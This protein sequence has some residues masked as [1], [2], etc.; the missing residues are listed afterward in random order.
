MNQIL[1]IVRNIFYHY[2]FIRWC[3]ASWYEELVLLPVDEGEGD[4]G[5][6]HP[7][8]WSE[9]MRPEEKLKYCIIKCLNPCLM[10][11]KGF[12]VLEE[13]LAELISSHTW[14]DTSGKGDPA[15]RILFINH[16]L[17]Q[18]KL[19]SLVHAKNKVGIITLI[20]PCDQPLH[21]WQ[22][23]NNLHSKK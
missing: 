21:T 17:C 12:R 18:T 7:A 2:A 10:L 15:W 20:R 1:L 11:C 5:L 8:G 16:V 9:V 19:P 22:F 6:T 3:N 4:S 13:I 14:R 23:Q